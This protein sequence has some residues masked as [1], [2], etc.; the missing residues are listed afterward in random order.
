MYQY[1]IELLSSSAD[2]GRN[3]SL[4]PTHCLRCEDFFP[5]CIET[6]NR[7]FQVFHKT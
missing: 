5:L 4:H 1:C 6:K 3:E 2:V 7:Y